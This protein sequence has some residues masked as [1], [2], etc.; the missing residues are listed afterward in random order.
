MEINLGDD[1]FNAGQ[2]ERLA[3]EIDDGG[4][5]PFLY[6]DLVGNDRHLFVQHLGDDPDEG[7]VAFGAFDPDDPSCL[8]VIDREDGVLVNECDESVTY[9]LDGEGLRAVPDVGRGRRDLRRRQRAHHL[10]DHRQLAQS[11]RATSSA[12]WTLLGAGAGE[13]VDGDPALRHLV[14]GQALVGPRLEVRPTRGSTPP[15]SRTAAA[16]TSP[17]R[18]SGSPTTLA[19]STSGCCSSTCSTSRA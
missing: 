2:T 11:N 15:A 1:R 7:W 17:R 14:V 12:F 6:Q 19:S 16:G 5:L 3:E 13:L 9:P 4:G 10:D 18:S 8:V